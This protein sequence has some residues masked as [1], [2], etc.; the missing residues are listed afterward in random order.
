MVLALVMAGCKK[1]EASQVVSMPISVCLSA[2]DVV[3]ARNAAPIRRAIGDPGTTEKYLFPHHLY[4]IVMRQTGPTT[5]TVWTQEHRTLKDGDWIP[6]RYGWTLPTVGDSIYRYDAEITMLLTSSDKF[7]GHVYAIASA[8]ELTFNKSLDAI[9]SMSDVL[10]LTF[11]TASD[12]IQENLQHIY[13]SPYNLEQDGAYYGSFDSKHQRVPRIDML[14]YHVAA[15]VDIKWSVDEEKRINKTD[16][17]EAIRL[18]YMKACNL[19]DGYAYCFRPM[20]NELP[21]KLTSGYDLTN[22]VTADDEGLWWEGRSYF[23]TIPY[24]VTGEAVE[25]KVYFPLQMKMETNSSGKYYLPTLNLKVDT[26]AVF[27][28]W[29][30]AMFNINTK[31]ED[32]SETIPID[33]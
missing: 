20:R 11:S 22:I 27:V 21:A 17:S 7:V 6:G 26:T 14:L 23:Y 2:D 13:T 33:L 30:R 28:P 5:W 3:S 12:A 8:E 1:D 18:T 24:V 31:L 4:F 15:K 29:M 16:P 10:N 19:F 32:K 25:G 9:S